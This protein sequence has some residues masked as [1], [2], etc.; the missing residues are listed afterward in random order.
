MTH[1]EII[2]TYNEQARATYFYTVDH[3][4]ATL[5]KQS[6]ESKKQTLD[7]IKTLGIKYDARLIEEKGRERLY[8]LELK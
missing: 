2:E 8:Q 3:K 4:D 1:Q 5:A 6:L 7:M